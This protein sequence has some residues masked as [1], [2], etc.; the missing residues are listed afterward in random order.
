MDLFRLC[1][2][3][4]V[5]LPPIIVHVS[6]HGKSLCKIIARVSGGANNMN[7]LS[8][9]GTNG[10]NSKKT[11]RGHINE[12][13]VITLSLWKIK[14]SLFKFLIFCQPYAVQ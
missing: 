5:M 1:P 12:E 10:K 3:Q 8:W 13:S 4:Y 11:I 6:L 2:P 14:I 7:P 9:G